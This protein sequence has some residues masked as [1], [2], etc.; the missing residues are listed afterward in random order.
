ME[1]NPGKTIGSATFLA[2]F[3]PNAERILGGDEIIIDKAGEPHVVHK[4]GIAEG[5]LQRLTE[6]VQ[7]GLTWLWRGIATVVVGSIA[8]FAAI[9]LSG[10]WRREK[11]RNAESASPK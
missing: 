4:T 1:A 3:L 5:P 11:I 7:E 2:V 9:K 6:P 10:V 8:I